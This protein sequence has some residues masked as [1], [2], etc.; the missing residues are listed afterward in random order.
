MKRH[1]QNRLSNRESDMNTKDGQGREVGER[2]ERGQY[3]KR[4]TSNKLIGTKGLQ[5]CLQVWDLKD[6]MGVSFN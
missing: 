2:E 1:A 4:Q 6:V 3:R 5:R